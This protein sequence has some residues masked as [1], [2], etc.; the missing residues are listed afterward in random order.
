M[1]NARDEFVGEINQRDCAETGAD[2]GR[3]VGLRCE[4]RIVC[5]GVGD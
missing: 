1:M 2:G 5:C 4:E 3:G